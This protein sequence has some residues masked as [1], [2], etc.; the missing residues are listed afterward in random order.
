MDLR[1]DGPKREVQAIA[2]TKGGDRAPDEE[3]D[4]D[5]RWP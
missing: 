5:A 4:D 2:L 3:H 1:P